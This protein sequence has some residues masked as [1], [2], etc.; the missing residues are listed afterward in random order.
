MKYHFNTETGKV[1]ECRAQ[2]GNCP[3]AN[4]FNHFDSMDE[5][6]KYSDERI[7]EAMMY[8]TTTSLR[9]HNTNTDILHARDVDAR[10]NN[11][12]RKINRFEKQELPKLYDEYSKKARANRE[13]EIMSKE[14]FKNHYLSSSNRRSIAY[15][16]GQ[17][18]NLEKEISSLVKDRKNI[19]EFLK[20]TKAGIVEV[21]YSNASCS[22]YVI[23]KKSYTEQLLKDLKKN[24]YD[25]KAIELLSVTSGD[26]FMVRFSDHHPKDYYH[27]P[28]PRHPEDNVFDY[29]DASVLVNV[30]SKR[31]G[32]MYKKND[33]QKVSI[34]I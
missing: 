11:L 27:R 34:D 12:R 16:Y 23:Y 25:Y 13:P 3:L 19:N 1:S 5:A 8:D 14:K 2:D 20:K 17:Y 18:K 31:D 30:K 24:G 10:I 29:T 32:K 15:T 6:Q 4:G 7:K 28:K 21:N 22:T 33:L 9:A 26:T